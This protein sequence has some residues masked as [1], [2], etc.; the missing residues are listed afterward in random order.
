MLR[1]NIV[2]KLSMS[3]A[4][5]A[6]RLVSEEMLTRSVKRPE[7]RQIIAR[8]AGISLGSLEGLSRGRLKYI[9]RIAD[10]LNALLIRKIEAR[11]ASL[12]HE[13]E[14]ARLIGD[15]SDVDLERAEA[16]LKD[17]R[18]ALGK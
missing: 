9:D 12:Q 5:V 17:A 10:R 3:V 2:E 13:L 4:S 15:V 7:A 6:A 11:I 16:A 8:E 1:T 14:I 18:Q